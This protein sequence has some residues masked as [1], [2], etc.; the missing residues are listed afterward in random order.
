[1]SSQSRYEYDENS[2]T[3]PYFVLT[4]ILVP[5]IPITISKI[6]NLISNKS[7][8]LE[9][10]KFKSTKNWFNPYN[11]KEI[12]NFKSLS[13]RSKL[14]SKQNIF[15]SIGW[16]LI[17]VLYL[18]ISSIIIIPSESHFDP[19]KILEISESATEK[20]IK[21]AYRKLS[22][23]YHPDKVDTSSMPQKDID[24]VD[25]AYVLINK[26]YKALTDETV[27]ENFLK[28]G[29][30]D[31]P[32]EIKHGIALPKFLID[33]PTSPFL[34]LIYVLLIAVILPLFVRSWW[35]GVKS[36]TKN[37]IHVDTADHFMKVM[38]NANPMKLLLVDDIIKF[39][40]NSQEYFDID[41]SLTPNKVESLLMSY[42]NREP[43]NEETLR[44]K[45]VA[46]TPKL[47][48]AFIEI[49]AGFKNT[50]YCLK[51][52]DTHRCIIQ[53]LNIDKDAKHNQ[54]KQILQLPGV[55]ASKV[56]FKQ[57]MITLGKLLKK[58]TIDPSKFLGTDEKITKNIL[59]YAKSIP[60]IEPL[61][62]SFKVPSENF[63]PPNSSANINLKFIIKSPLHKSKPEIKDLS[64]IVIE[65]Q[66]KEEESMENMRDP[67][68][69]VEKQNIFELDNLPPFF[70]D[71]E[72]IQNNCGW[73]AFLVAQR[74]NKIIEIPKQIIRAESKNLKLTQEEF[75]KS[76]CEVSTFKIQL[77]APSPPNVG[78]YQ[79]RLII[80]N[81]VYFG[82]DVDIPLVM[83]VED[84]P[85]EIPGKDLYEIE[86]PD[87][88][89]IAGAMATI[90][91]DPVK[92]IE[93]ENEYESS[94]DEG[95]DE[96]EEELW[97]DIDTDTE[98]EEDAVDLDENQ[99]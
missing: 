10:N 81:L 73:I 77:Q 21:S 3:W 80:R 84:K 11:I 58:P 14:F 36:M 27:R 92:K 99:K 96:E 74:D 1:M 19:W 67:M 24:A 23:K 65:T 46:I 31:G 6:S 30:P 75:A 45:V 53:A 40:S 17:L 48:A 57:N 54:F 34:V 33:G 26:A 69:V 22:L 55:D 56:D 60:L 32:N 66:F 4:T 8:K 90:R 51:L 52:V 71:E 43:S 78:E 76:D 44:L 86:D 94:D 39:I 98:V 13:E 85:V 83:K 50:E 15:I 95:D 89:S 88:D 35:N 97:T 62:C 49:A 47:I 18:K 12:K 63:I 59:N 25:S 9:S 91:G 64:K 87:E 2:E 20:V 82:S 41:I 72:Y 70:P 38:I 79:F 68:K 61:E 29:N 28:Y 7:K 16:I 93:F 5:L 37:G 42:I